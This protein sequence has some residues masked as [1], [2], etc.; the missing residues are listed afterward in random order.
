MRTYIR[1]LTTVIGIVIEEK[2]EKLTEKWAGHAQLARMD[3]N[4]W[5]EKITD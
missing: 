4:R 3:N 2:S 5:A 1:Q